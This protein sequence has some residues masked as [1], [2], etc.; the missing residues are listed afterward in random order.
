MAGE[1][2]VAG[3]SRQRGLGEVPG[4]SLRS[5]IST[6]WIPMKSTPMAGMRIRRWIAVLRRG[7]VAGAVTGTGAVVDVV[8]SVEEVVVV[9]ASWLANSLLRRSWARCVAR[10]VPHS[11]Y[12]TKSRMST[13]ARIMNRPIAPTTR[14]HCTP[15]P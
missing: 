11:W 9:P 12:A 15:G 10:P 3:L 7:E 8:D 1:G 14:H 13:P 5:A 6:P 4:P 2:D